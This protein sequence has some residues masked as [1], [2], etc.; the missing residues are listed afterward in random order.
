MICL[1]CFKLH[2]NVILL[3]VRNIPSLTIEVASSLPTGAGLGSS[4]AYSTCL[5]SSLLQH[6][7]LTSVALQVDK[8]NT[9][10][11]SDKDVKLINQW[12]FIGEKVIHGN[13]SGIDNS[14]STYGE[15]VSVLLIH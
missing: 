1:C 5:A 11:W 7:R 12:A 10:T 9:A 3:C 14:V 4:A 15:F 8:S 2:Q 13:P 6:R